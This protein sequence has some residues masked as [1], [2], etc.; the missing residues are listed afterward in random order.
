MLEKYRVAGAPY[1]NIHIGYNHRRE[2]IS[3]KIPSLA[4]R[5]VS[6]RND[7]DFST[8]LKILEPHSLH[9]KIRDINSKLR[10]VKEFIKYENQL[11]GEGCLRELQEEDYE[12][13]EIVRKEYT[14]C[15][16]RQSLQY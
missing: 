4:R 2:E 6:F 13:L 5:R 8:V 11:L 15:K 1:H 3:C 12:K 10:E 7:E 14:A 16:K 9:F